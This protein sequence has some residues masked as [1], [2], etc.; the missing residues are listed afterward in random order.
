MA[1]KKQIIVVVLGAV[2]I[3]TALLVI[4]GMTGTGND[5]AHAECYYP[6]ILSGGM[7]GTMCWYEDGS[8]LFCGQTEAECLDMLGNKT[9]NI[10]TLCDPSY[11]DFCLPYGI[12]DLDCDDIVHRGFSVLPPDRNR[13]DADRDGIGCET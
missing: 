9:V 10:P 11:P 8:V 1:D 5:I 2:L 7:V 3:V 13:F 12:A 6:F 4:W